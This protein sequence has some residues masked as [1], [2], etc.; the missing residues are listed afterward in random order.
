MRT[1]LTLSLRS[2]A[3]RA[4]ERR[5]ERQLFE[6]LADRPQ[7]VRNEVLEMLSQAS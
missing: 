2:F 6:Q 5:A 1:R 4:T 3:A 7:N